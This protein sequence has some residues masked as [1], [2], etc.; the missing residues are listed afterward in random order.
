MERIWKRKEFWYWV[1]LAAVAGLLAFM[2][3]RLGEMNNQFR[4]LGTELGATRA[5]ATRVADYKYVVDL[6]RKLYWPNEPRYS[7]SIDSKYRVYVQDEETMRQWVGYKPGP[8]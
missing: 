3:L 8:R 7:M 6:E 1:I 2:M 4:E 5:G